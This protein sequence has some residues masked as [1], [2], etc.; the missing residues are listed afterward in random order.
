MQRKKFLYLLV[1][2]ILVLSAFLPILI[3]NIRAEPAPTLILIKSKGKVGEIIS[4][5]GT[6]DTEN[7]FYRILFGGREVANGTADGT[8]VETEFA[9][10]NMP[11]GTYNATL[12][13]VNASLESLP[14]KFTI[15]TDYIL[16]VYKPEKPYQFVEGDNVTISL[17]IRGGKNDTVYSLNMTVSFQN[18]TSYRVIE[19]ATNSSG[20]ASENVTYPIGFEGAASTNYTGIYHVKLIKLN[21]TVAKAEF[22]VGITE[23]TEYHRGDTVKIHAIG[24]QSNASV[25]VNVK[26]PNGHLESNTTT[27]D[28]SGIVDFNWAVPMDAPMGDYLLWVNDT[29]K[30]QDMQNF[31][32]PGFTVNI[33]TV[34]L[35]GKPVSSVSLEIFENKTSIYNETTTERGEASVKLEKGNYTWRATFNEKLVGEG[36]F[37]TK[38]IENENITLQISLSSLKIFVKNEKTGG[39]VSFTKIKLFC[40]YI[41]INN[42]NRSLTLNKET[43]INGTAEFVNIFINESYTIEAYKYGA[44]FNRTIFFIEVSDEPVHFVNVTYPAKTSTVKVLDCRG[45]SV[46]GLIVKAYEWT[47]G[48]SVPTAEE[49]SDEN[50][51]VTLGLTFGW[52][53][54]RVFKPTEAGEILVNET[55]ADLTIQNETVEMKI[56]C[57]LLGLNLAVRVIDI[58]GSPIPNV[59]VRLELIS[60]GLSF[61]KT[62]D[63]EFRFNDVVGGKYK[64]LVFLPNDDA[65]Y[66]IDTVYL[67]KPNTIITLRDKDHINL[68]GILIGTYTLVMA[69]IIGVVAALIVMVVVSRRLSKRWISKEKL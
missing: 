36:N 38:G 2:S 17:T 12:F 65:P 7:G 8:K 35:A 11:A 30:C 39:G 34:N 14:V 18:E 40:N 3:R 56:K 23:L 63:G 25:T 28:P 46:Q 47:N 58:L 43:D 22:T 50:G 41:T 13:D 29:K 48:T 4:V 20:Y 31:T 68:F 6:I 5:N 67:D 15:E 19:L 9:V 33:T 69:I 1:A 51:V 16:D 44:L 53:R 24:Y 60:T 10:P 66:L 32:V 45:N 21:E 55:K 64:I 57:K 61:N 27:A 26:F 37:T 49:E 42:E 59:T 62:A 54:I 52:Y